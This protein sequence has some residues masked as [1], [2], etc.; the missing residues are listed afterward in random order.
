MNP[1]DPL[2]L[3]LTNT[4][5]RTE[6]E[7]GILRLCNMHL[8]RITLRNSRTPHFQFAAISTVEFF[9]RDDSHALRISD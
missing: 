2:R 4:Y 9:L 1:A 6:E 5:M 7:N 8:K 3:D